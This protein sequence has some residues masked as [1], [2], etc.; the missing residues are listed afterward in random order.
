MDKGTLKVIVTFGVVGLL[1]SV[2]LLFIPGINIIHAVGVGLAIW[3]ILT[4]IYVFVANAG[5]GVGQALFG[6][7]QE[8]DLKEITAES[9][10]EKGVSCRKTKNFEDAIGHFQD[11]LFSGFDK[12]QERTALWIAQIYENDI[13][14][15][16][17]AKYWYHKSIAFSCKEGACGENVFARESHTAIAGLQNL[18]N[19]LPETVVEGLKQAKNYIESKNY[20][21]AFY[22]LK[23][24][25]KLHPHNA[26]VNYLFAHYYLR[27]NNLG[28]ALE[29]FS[30]SLEKNSRHPLAAYYLACTRHEIGHLIQAKEELNNYIEMVK[31]DPNEAERI[32][33]AHLRLSKIEAELEIQMPS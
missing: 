8:V 21:E 19:S 30:R 26:D 22:R 27:I 17:E 29:H 2:V 9:A 23:K 32:K 12:S 6:L 15:L 4:S 1:F 7:G 20:E 33:L 5:S 13:K 16:K 14:D 31:D 10:F 24:L 25:E 11:F 18:E 28:M 3:S